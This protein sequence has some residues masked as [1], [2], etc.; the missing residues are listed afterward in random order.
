M[1]ALGIYIIKKK[2]STTYTKRKST[3]K[4]KLVTIGSHFLVFACDA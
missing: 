2:G 1:W 4:F 3:K